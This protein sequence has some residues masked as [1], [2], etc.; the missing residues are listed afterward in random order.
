M[1]YEFVTILNCKQVHIGF[2]ST[3]RNPGYVHLSPKAIEDATRGAFGSFQVSV[4]DVHTIGTQQM[5]HK[6]SVTESEWEKIIQENKTILALV[7]SQVIEIESMIAQSRIDAEKLKLLSQNNENPDALKLE[8]KADSL[9]WAHSSL[10]KKQYLH[11]AL[12]VLHHLSCTTEPQKLTR[13]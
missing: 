2:D 5:F 13:T 12:A 7:T 1:Y 9:S 3:Y 8:E 11:Q 10:L 6:H 4:C